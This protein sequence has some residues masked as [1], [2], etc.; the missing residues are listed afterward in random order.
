MN[1]TDITKLLMDMH[2]TLGA[3]DAK[4]TALSYDLEAHSKASTETRRDVNEIQKE[5]SRAKGAIATILSMGALG[6]AIKFLF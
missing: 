4:V 6:T 5:V 3:I 2:A 1:T